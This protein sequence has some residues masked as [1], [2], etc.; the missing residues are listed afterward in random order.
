MPLDTVPAGTCT[1]CFGQRALKGGAVCD[2]CADLQRPDIAL[3]LGYSI[4]D[5]F[6]LGRVLGE[7]GGFGITY[8]GW[9]RRLRRRV[10]IK[11]FFP[12]HLAARVQ[13]SGKISAFSVSAE[14]EFEVSLAGFLAEARRLAMLDHPNLV[15]V[16]DFQGANGTGYLMMNY[17][18][19]ETLSAY[20]ERRG[21]LLP[22]S[23]AAAIGI[24]L[25][26]GLQAVHDAG[27]LHRDIKPDNVYLLPRKGKH[28]QPI[29][30]DFGAARQLSKA[31]HMTAILTEGFAPLEQYPECG[32]QGPYTDVYAVAATLYCVSVGLI[33]PPAP[34][35]LRG[36]VP[37]APADLVPG[38]PKEASD[39]L[40]AGLAMDAEERPR[41]AAAFAHLLEHGP[42]PVTMP[43]TR[44]ATERETAIV[45]DTKRIAPR[46]AAGEVA[47]SRRRRKFAIGVTAGVLVGT[48]LGVTWKLNATS[49]GAGVPDTTSQGAAPAT[50]PPASVQAAIQ[51]TTAG[52][53]LT[54]EQLGAVERQLSQA[55][56]AMTSGNYVVAARGVRNGID[57]LLRG[58]TEAEFLKGDDPAG[59]RLLE[60]ATILRADVVRACRAE[61]S[62]LASRGERAPDCDHLN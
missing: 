11:E 30:I 21:G 33:P 17:Y 27:L 14:R 43:A 56:T 61:A 24:E 35:R 19:G 47:K 4:A 44:P 57:A 31:T 55:R 5:R 50:S 38:F 28:P 39:A 8:L 6:D 40:L 42:S 59:H 32:P 9:D 10:A 3:P 12:R 51:P 26:G 48:V 22:W 58:A 13:S 16:L 46:P 20:V 18:E 41:T 45:P 62:M 15:K 52:G 23:E 37:E 7:P 60:Q 29:L 53:A 2:E 49:R 34:S 54:K 25:L 36:V 1:S